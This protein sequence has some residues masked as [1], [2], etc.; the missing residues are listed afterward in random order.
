MGKVSI[1]VMVKNYPS[2]EDG[3]LSVVG[4]LPPWGRSPPELSWKVT[5][6]GKI[7]IGV[8]LEGSSGGEDCHRSVV[9]WFPR[10]GM[11]FQLFSESFLH[12][13]INRERFAK[14]PHPNHLK[15]CPVSPIAFRG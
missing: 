4:R 6:V 3:H 15:K 1:G 2:G 12:R 5:P 8:L 13:N 10:W 9:G 11:F 14:H 7:A